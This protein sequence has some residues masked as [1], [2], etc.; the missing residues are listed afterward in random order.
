MIFC[1]KF[2]EIDGIAGAKRDILILTYAY[3]CRG[4]AEGMRMRPD[5]PF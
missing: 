2:A 4:E 3:L 1:H 5:P